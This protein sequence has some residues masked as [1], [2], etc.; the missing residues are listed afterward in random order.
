MSSSI[1]LFGATSLLGFHLGTMF[2]EVVLP[3]I[4]P[5]N[6]AKTV[7]RWPVLQL[8]DSVWIADV[9]QRTQPE[10][11]VYCHAVCDVA[12]CEASPGWAYEM[13]VGQ[14]GRVLDVLPAHARF[15]YVSSDHVFGGDGVYDEHCEPAPISVYGRT[16]VEAERLVLK[17]ADSLVLR[18]GLGIGVSPDGRTGHLDWLQYRAKRKLP[19]T[20][21]EDEY[22]STVWQC[23][24]AMR[25]MAFAQAKETGLRHM[26]A[27]RA[28]SRVA[29]ANFL[30]RQ[31]HIPATFTVE[32]RHQQPHPH[33][34]RV[35]LA[36]V[37][38]DEASKPLASVLDDESSR[39]SCVS[40]GLFD[41]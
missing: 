28:I 31:F 41:N 40:N 25:V 4:S 7:R 27:T 12:K 8:H 10:A 5:G 3:F 15:V 23:D 30:I 16:R 34:G 36:T 13:N 26:T 1:L 22:R 21:I 24:L 39:R 29:L 18:T 20:I 2:P 11:L 37:F 35:E 19:I 6:T 17:R 32:T 33:L 9:F 14:L 38:H